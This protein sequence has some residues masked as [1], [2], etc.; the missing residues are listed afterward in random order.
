[1]KALGG[2]L[3]VVAIGSVCI[4]GLL[5]VIAAMMGPAVKDAREKTKLAEEKRRAEETPKQKTERIAQEKQSSRKKTI[6][7]LFSVWDGSNRSIVNVVKESMND[8]KSFEHVSTLYWDKG[9]YVLVKM[10]YRGKN[11]FGG[12]VKNGVQAHLDT[13]G[14]ILEIKQ[15]EL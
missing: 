4:F 11:A 15:L 10:Q 2:C 3:R 7:Q 12:V 8:P 1:M 6:E 13:A 14:N 9:D 5:F